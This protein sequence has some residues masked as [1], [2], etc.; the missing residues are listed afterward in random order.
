MSKEGSHCEAV[1]GDHEGHCRNPA[2]WRMIRVFQ[3]QAKQT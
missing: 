1:T 3:P 2:K